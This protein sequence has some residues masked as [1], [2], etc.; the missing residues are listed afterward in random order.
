MKF[1]LR[2]KAGIWKRF[3]KASIVFKET[4]SIKPMAITGNFNSTIMRPSC[5]LSN[6]FKFMKRR[7][8]RGTFIRITTINLFIDETDVNCF[9]AVGMPLKP[10]CHSRINNV[11]YSSFCHWIKIKFTRTDLAVTFDVNL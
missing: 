8:Q 6:V 7:Y 5:Q 2:K 10:R 1:L 9:R 4:S 3:P 11:S